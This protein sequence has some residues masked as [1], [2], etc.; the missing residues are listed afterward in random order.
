M[1]NLKKLLDTCKNEKRDL[2]PLTPSQMGVY[3]GCMNCPQGTMY[4]T[5]GIFKFEKGTLDIDRLK[6]AIQTTVNNHP[7]MK[8]CIDTS[9]G[10]PMMK[11]R[12]DVRVEVPVTKTA[13]L[14][15]A[16]R[17]FIRPFDLE[18]DNL[19]RFEIFESKEQCMFAMDFHHI[20]WNIDVY[21]VQR[22][23]TCL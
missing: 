12:D 5:P 13:D 17:T 10:S 19:F 6:A 2:Y 18:N 9:T 21:C 7:I 3:F 14:D 20:R 15:Q 1:A 8:V 16:I 11:M 23:G 22:C 4:N